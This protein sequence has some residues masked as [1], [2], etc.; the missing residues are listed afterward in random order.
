MYASAV[1]VF[2]F[3]GDPLARVTRR[4]YYTHARVIGARVG[5]DSKMR[6]AQI[7]TLRAQIHKLDAERRI[8]AG[9]L[10][11]LE[12]E[13]ETIIKAKKR[14][15]WEKLSTGAKEIRKAKKDIG[16]AF[17][18]ES[19][20][21]EAMHLSDTVAKRI[22]KTII[23]AGKQYADHAACGLEHKNSEGKF[24]RVIK[25]AEHE[26]FMSEAVKDLFLEG[27]YKVKWAKHKCMY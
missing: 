23:K 7:M 22:P 1:P 8:L 9:Q 14:I 15:E 4:P 3:P 5:G 26:K 16:K 19:V 18:A 27:M 24:N 17:D 25:E 2:S 13:K 6:D 11:S 10:N 12:L 20:L 21:G